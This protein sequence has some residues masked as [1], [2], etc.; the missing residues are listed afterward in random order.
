MTAFLLI[1]SLFVAA[2]LLFVVPP[3]LSRGPRT[4]VS[5][6]L[7]NTAVYADQLREI[8]GDLRAGT[9]S[10]SDYE[11]ARGELERRL[12]DD[13]SGDEP[14]APRPAAA[15]RGALALA[16][17]VPLIA[18]AVYFAVGTPAALDPK[19][20]LAAPAVDEQQIREMVERLAERL[21]AEPENGEGWA[22]LG[23]S[24]SV[25]GRFDEAARAYANAIARLPANADLLADYAHAAAM[26]QGQTLQGEPEKILARALE[27]DAANLKAL[28]LA[29]SA[30]FEKKN[31]PAAV[32]HW[33]R[34]LAVVPPDSDI[35]R[36]VSTNIEEARALAAGK[37][38]R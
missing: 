33:Q 8:E 29:G 25:M 37:P 9:L 12:L 21:K 22:M 2:A 4:R 15:R 1:A 31:Y 14:A 18:A 38:T 10:A 23:R 6:D 27:I 3:L 7:L 11:K 17:V 19:A 36:S 34:L 24:Y 30:E 28:A 35:A 20:T 5:L 13:V 16:L 32:A 26:A